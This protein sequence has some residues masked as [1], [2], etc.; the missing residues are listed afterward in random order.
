MSEDKKEELQK[1][2]PIKKESVEEKKPVLNI[3][4]HGAYRG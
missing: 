2:K 1:P 3:P 4:K